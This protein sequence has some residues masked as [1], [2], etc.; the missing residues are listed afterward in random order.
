MTKDSV[1]MFESG[2]G[3]EPST[4]QKTSF[5]LV[6]DNIINIRKETFDESLLEKIKKGLRPADGDEKTLPTLL[7]YDTQGLK[8][9][10]K[11]TY[12]DEY[13]LT[14][15]EIDVLTAYADE[16]AKR[17]QPGG[18]VVEL[19][20][21]ALRKICILLEALERA[22]K[23][24]RYYAL[25]LSREELE[26]TLA[27]V[28]KFKHV[29]CFGLH[30]TYD[31]G[32]DWLRTSETATTRQTNILSLGSSIGNFKRHE[33]A[34]FLHHFSD[35]LKS[36]DNMIIGMDGCQDKDRAYHAY[37]DRDGVT[38]EFILNGLRHANH[39][40]GREEFEIKKWRVIGEYDES[41]RRHHAFV[42]PLQDVKIDGVVIH[43]D[44]RV[45]IEESYKFSDL[46]V[47]RL[48]KAASL[49]QGAKWSNKT[50][51]YGVYMA[52]KPSFAYS[53][54]PEEYAAKPVPTSVEWDNLWR[55]WDTVTLQMIP[56]EELLSKPI[57]LRNACIFY[58]GHI[59][60]FLAIHLHRATGQG[61]QGLDEYRRIFERGI[62]PD[63]DN[64]ELCHDHSEIPT[65][66]PSQKDIL[67]FQERVRNHVKQIYASGDA[68]RKMAVQK[69]IWISFEHEVMHLE[70]LLYMLVQSEKT[71]PPTGIPA[72]DF[73]AMAREAQAKAVPNE[74][75]NVPE[76][77]ITLGLCD[78]E[79]DS[80]TER[81]FGWDNERPPRSAT[82]PAF[83]SKATA[84]TNGDYAR[85]MQVTGGRKMPESW[86]IKDDLTA[87]S[88]GS[89]SES[90]S[91]SRSGSPDHAQHGLDISKF[92]QDK[93]VKTVFG[94]VPL[95]FALD[96][97]VMA[98]YNELAGCA[99]WMGGRIPTLEEVKS[100]YE[101]V[102]LQKQKQCDKAIGA[103]IPAVNGH[104]INDGVEETPPSSHSVNGLSSTLAG[105][106]P[107]A[108][109][110]NLEDANVG[111]KH[112]HPTPVT[113][114]GGRLAGQGEFGGAW[115]WTS[116]VLEKHEGFKPMALYP[117][118]T[119]GFRTL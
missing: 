37:N 61:V 8:L 90:T 116:S 42:S 47:S 91:I 85:Y 76:Q 13:Y 82:V 44:E 114:H 21:G 83:S 64:P 14:N 3:L 112:W 115:E 33:G 30:G 16:I 65:E 18:I 40:F 1:A 2:P 97:P 43:K 22:E 109:F 78:E 73:E 84:I 87:S 45:R 31:D 74:W 111:F 86:F 95:E 4:V 94:K 10:E 81:Y 36:G 11:I 57:K 118:Y 58:L 17:I 28:P 50:G 15:A 59:P 27:E 12:L 98:S 63:V 70:T 39:L 5:G 107:S 23:N 26:R 68:N 48:W 60:T 67:A 51:D 52:Y 56:E 62:D 29:E 35:I 88:D 108:Y 41:A 96:W 9:F 103:T 102:Y 19:G 80:T 105:P 49:A 69:A 106:S 54:R 119:G 92:I 93:A 66:W 99:T 55:A 20:S 46:D 24:I 72:P 101:Y 32:L 117:A 110:V 7:L 25:D 100:I 38:H 34:E 79:D 104:L 53:L 75:F 113:S 89:R 6:Q 77:R 71:Q